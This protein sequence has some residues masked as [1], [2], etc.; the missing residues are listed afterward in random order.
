MN[1]SDHVAHFAKMLRNVDAWLE[2]GVAHA[3]AKSF[4][5]DVLAGCRLAPDMYPL[6]RQVG[7]ACDAA[8][9]SAVYLANKQAPAHPDTETTIVEIRRRIESVLAW[10]DTVPSDDYAG[11]GDRRVSPPWLG[12]RW[13][14]GDDYLM[15]VAIP[16]FHFHVSMAYAI[17]RH[18][19]VPLGKGDFLGSL[20][21]RD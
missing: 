19:G 5:P 2:K 10:L 7:S 3:K 17:L 14:S 8:K 15:E 4:D 6:T 18:N 20:T 16:N 9:F 1:T 11:A 21:A 13:M 12:G